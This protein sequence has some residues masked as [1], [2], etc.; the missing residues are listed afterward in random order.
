MAWV[1]ATTES[2]GPED[3]RLPAARGRVLAEAIHALGTHPLRKSRGVGRLCHPGER[4]LGGKL[5]QSNPAAID[6]RE[7]RRCF[8][9]RAWTARRKPDPGTD[10]KCCQSANRQPGAARSALR[11]GLVLG[12]TAALVPLIRH[13]SRTPAASA[14]QARIRTKKRRRV[15]GHLRRRSPLG[16]VRHPKPGTILRAACEQFVEQAEGEYGATVGE[17]GSGKPVLSTVL[18]ARFG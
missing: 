4:I 16:L 10:P 12:S 8:A 13:G 17:T 3:V 1:D 5:L 9:G 6:R 18:R 15:G 11:R 7:C 14:I 2:L